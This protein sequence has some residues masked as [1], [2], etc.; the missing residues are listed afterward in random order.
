MTVGQNQATRSYYIY[1]LVKRG[2]ACSLR[3]ISSHRRQCIKVCDAWPGYMSMGVPQGSVLGPLLFSL[4]T[5]N[6]GE[7]CTDM[8]PD[9]NTYTCQANTC[10]AKDYTLARSI[11]YDCKC[12]EEKI[13][14]PKPMIHRPN[15]DILT[16]GKRIDIVT[17][18]M[19][20]GVTLDPNLNFKKPVKNFKGI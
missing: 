14:F 5:N 16:R 6:P 10:T 12:K 3:H 13:G 9:M 2:V 17:K 19:H 11:M 8:N 4:Y 15:T 20:L 18:C 1:L 7:E